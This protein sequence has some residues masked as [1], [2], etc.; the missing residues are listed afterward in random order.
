MACADRH[1]EL[2]RADASLMKITSIP[3]IYRNVNRWGEILT[4]LY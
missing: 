1:R 4:I 3:H 2:S